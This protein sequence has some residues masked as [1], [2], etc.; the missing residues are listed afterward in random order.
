[1]KPGCGSVP[2]RSRS[3]RTARISLVRLPKHATDSGRARPPRLRAKRGGGIEPLDVN[4]VEIASPIADDDVLLRLSDALE[5]MRRWIRA[6]RA[7]QTALLRGM[8]HDETTATL[9][10]AVPT[11]KQ[12]WAYARA[13]LAVEMRGRAARLTS[14]PAPRKNPHTFALQK[15]HGSLRCCERSRISHAFSSTTREDSLSPHWSVR[16]TSAPLFSTTRVRAADVCGSD[17]RFAHHARAT[18]RAPT[19]AV[20]SWAARQQERPV[21]EALGRMIGRYKVMEKIGEGAAA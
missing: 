5:S 4:E 1:M 14:S 13:W 21:D 8:T 6:G 18:G 16:S 9:G 11:A 12:W 3:G 19:H 17:L 7:G 10:I 15:A 20:R 2:T